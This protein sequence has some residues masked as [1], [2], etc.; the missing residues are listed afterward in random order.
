MV[1]D[2]SRPYRKTGWRLVGLA[3]IAAAIG[4]PLSPVI[5]AATPASADIAIPAACSAGWTN[6][7][8][9]KCVGSNL[10]VT[11]GGNNESSFSYYATA[12]STADPIS[13]SFNSTLVDHPAG[14][15]EGGDGMAI[16]LYDA[17]KGTPGAPGQRG[18]GLGVG[19]LPVAG[20]GLDTYQDPCDP[21]IGFV[22]LTDGSTWTTNTCGTNNLHYLGASPQETA[23]FQSGEPVTVTFNAASSTITVSLGGTQ[24]FTGSLTIPANAYLFISGG[25]GAATNIE[26]VSNFSGSIA[27]PN[28][29]ATLTASSPTITA[30]RSVSDAALVSALTSSAGGTQQALSLGHVSLGHVSLGHVSL[31]HVSLGHV[32]LGH[33]SLGHVS[34]GHVAAA[35]QALA[36][37]TVDT[38]PVQYPTG[39]SAPAVPC[40]G[41]TG[42]LAGSGLAGA[43]LQG[44]TLAQVLADPDASARFDALPMGSVDFS[45]TPLASVPMSVIALAGTPLSSI[46]LPGVTDDSTTGRLQGWCNALAAQGYSSCFGIDPSQPGTASNISPLTLALAG[47]QVDNLSL[48]SISLGHVSLGHVSLGHV[49]LGQVDLSASSLGHVSL[50][51][52]SLGHVA[53][54]SIPVDALADPGSVVNCSATD[55][56]GTSF[57]SSS[58]D[59][60]ADAEAA[61]AVLPGA[62]LDD[63]ANLNAVSLGHVALSS[64]SLGHVSLGHV[65]LGQVDVADSSLGHVSL[66]HVSLGHVPLGEIPLDSIPSLG[67]VVDCSA[68]DSGGTSFCTS[69]TDTLADA[70]SANAVLATA[71]LGQLSNLDAASLG[72]VSLGHVNMATS[73]LGHVSLGQVDMADSSLGQVS[74]GHV[75]LG[76]V[77]LGEIPLDSISD[78]GAVVDC[79]ATDSSGNNLCS[80]SSDTLADAEVAGAILPTATLDQLTDLDQT[81]L[82]HVSLGHV[83]LSQSASLGQVELGAIPDLSSVV[84][85]S[86]SDPNSSP[87]A[88]FCDL[89]NDELWQA[90]AAGAVLPNATLADLGP[91]LGTTLGQLGTY[92]NATLADLGPFL[93]TTLAELGAYGNATLA[94]LG[95]FLSTTVEQLL[96]ELDP[97]DPTFSNM[98]LDDLLAG[99]LPPSTYPWDTV[100][101]STLPLDQAASAPATDTFTETLTDT[102]VTD[103]LSSFII[104]LP[105]GFTYV[106]GSTTADGNAVPDAT[107][108]INGNTLSA[109]SAPFGA[110]TPGTHTVTVEGYPG[111]SIGVGRATATVTGT[112]SASASTDVTVV[113]PAADGNTPSNPLPLLT[114]N[115]NFGHIGDAGAL[116]YWAITVNQGDE[117]ALELSNLPAD[118]DLALFSPAGTTSSESGQLQGAPSTQAP[119]VTD[120]QP[121]LSTS[122]EPIPGAGDVAQAA[123]P[124]FQTYAISDNRGNADEN[125]QTPPLDAGTYLVEVSGYNGDS[126]DAPYLLRATDLATNPNLTCTPMVNPATLTAPGTSDPVPANVNTII[127]VNTQALTA[128]VGAGQEQ[129]AWTAL[130]NLNGAGGVVSARIAVDADPATRADYAAWAGGNPCSVGAANQVVH[131]IISQLDALRA[132]HPSITSVV[133]V[134]G[135]DEIPFARVADGAAQANE[136]DYAAG[137]FPGESNALAQSLAEGYYLSDDPLT[138]MQPLGVGSATLYTP[139]LAVGRLVTTPSTPGSSSG[140]T[141]TA[142]I[143]AANRFVQYQGVLTADSELTTGYSFLTAGAQVVSSDLTSLT[144]Q[145]V[146]DLINESWTHQQLDTALSAGPSIVGLNAHFDFGRALPAAGNAS[147]DETDLFTTAD[148]RG[149]AQS[150]AGRL[151]FSMGCHSGLN[152]DDAEV[153]TSGIAS[154]VDDWAKTFADEGA[155]WIGNTGYGYADTDTI[156]YSAKLMA[157]FAG[158]LGLSPTIGAALVN[159]KQAYGAGDALLSPYDLKGLMEA[160]FYG[161]PMYKVSAT[162]TG[163]GAPPAPATSVDPYTGLS[164]A[165]ITVTPTFSSPQSPTGDPG[166]SYYETTSITVTDTN[167]TTYTQ[168]TGGQTQETEYRPLEP[169][170]TVDVTEPSGAV[171]HGALVTGLAS[172]D[173][174]IA[175][176][177]AQPDSAGGGTG[178]TPIAADAPFPNQI[179]RV[180]SSESLTNTGPVTHQYL[181]LVLG[182]YL[183]GSAPGQGTQRLFKKVGASVFFTAPTDQDFTPAAIVSDSATSTGNAVDFRV[184]TQDA[185]PVDRVLVLYTDGDNPGAWTP[186]NLG[187]SDGSNWTGTAPAPTSGQV[188]FVVQVLD[189]NGNVAVASNKGVG[190]PLTQPQGSSGNLTLSA[191]SVGPSGYYDAPVPVT[192]SGGTGTGF[193]YTIDGGPSTAVPANDQIIVTGDGTHVVTA[194]DDGGD[195]ASIVIRINTTPPDLLSARV[196]GGSPDVLPT[197]CPSKDLVNCVTGEQWRT[198]LDLTVPGRGLSLDLTRTYSSLAA[199]VLGPFGYGWTDSYNVFLSFS[200]TSVT[201]HQ[202]NGSTLTATAGVNGYVF[203][204][205]VFATLVQNLN[206]TFTFTTKT[207]TK[208]QFSAIG[209]LLSL[210]DRNGYVTSFTY[211]AAGQLTTVTDPAGRSLHFSYRKNLVSSVTDPAG[212]VVSYLYD[213]AGDLVRSYDAGRRAW[214]YSYDAQ[215]RMVGMSDPRGDSTTTVYDGTGRVVSQTDPMGRTTTHSYSAAAGT[216]FGSTTVTDPRGFQTV[217]DYAGGEVTST[218]QGVNTPQQ[219]TTSYTYDPATLAQTSSTDPRGNTTTS[220]YDGEGNLLSTT[221]PMGRTTSYTYNALNEP[222]TVTDPSGITTTSVYD[223]RGNLVSRTTGGETTSYTYGDALHPGDVTAIT[224]PDGYITHF[225]YDADGNQISVT[226]ADGNTSSSTY[227]GIGRMISSTTPNQKTTKYTYD[228]MDDLLTVTD[229][230]GHKATNVYDPA[231][232]VTATVDRSGNTTEYVYDRDNELTLTLQRGRT[233]R[234]AYDAAGDVISSTDGAGRVTNYEYD[235]LDRRTEVIDPLGHTTATAYDADGNAVSVT[236]PSGRVTSNAYDAD[237]ELTSTTYSDGMTPPVSYTY[238]AD[239]RRTSMTDGTGTTTYGYDPVGR[240]ASST[241]GDGQAVGYGYDADGRVTTLT[242]PNGENVTQGYDPDGNMTSVTDWL[243]HTTTFTYDPDG[244]QTTDTVGSATPVTNTSTYDGNDQLLSTTDSQGATTLQQ[245]DY[246]RNADGLVSSATPQGEPTQSYAYDNLNRL[247]RDGQGAYIYDRGDNLTTFEGTTAMRY[248][249]GDELVSSQVG[250]AITSYTYDAEGERTK[251][252]PPTGPSTSYIYDQAGNLVGFDR[253]STSATYT[254][255][256]DGLRMSKVVGSET[257]NSAYDTTGTAPRMLTDGTDNYIYGPQGLPLEVLTGSSI[258]YFF[259]HDQGGNTIM[260]TGDNGAAVATYTY[261]SFGRV[262]SET[263]SVTT[264]FLYD[265]Q[266]Q[267]AESGLYLTPPGYYD[268]GTGQLLRASYAYDHRGNPYGYA[269]EDPLNLPRPGGSQGVDGALNGPDGQAPAAP[270]T[271]AAVGDLGIEPVPQPGQVSGDLSYSRNADVT[272][273]TVSNNKV[274]VATT[275]STGMTLPPNPLVGALLRLLDL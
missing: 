229:P 159:A 215:H 203:P 89:P 233:V 260:L 138:A 27:Q 113:D 32:S 62:T 56:G 76:H 182:Q 218:T 3:V 85:C 151:L 170:G 55:S 120:N 52:V 142:I 122:P 265:G 224:D 255:D 192:V 254:Y 171:A 177:V 155:L 39:C 46:L 190:F 74:L 10:E 252:S 185:S 97:N 133:V 167:N 65:S 53:M 131:D 130:G 244:N 37:I 41:W 226:D 86:V 73:S 94:D 174:S 243:G 249:A 58:T 121:G 250:R 12:L 17:S 268:P 201:L 28:L 126:S 206:G 246:T 71:T 158:E 114:D 270:V 92:G 251:T 154:G 136:R 50:G 163:A 22:G 140:D 124:G 166:T 168:P 57:C 275:A 26:T 4:A 48:D 34:L 213:A 51:H 78:V 118:Y 264:P 161:L 227:D 245:Y 178:S 139:Q 162:E 267:D 108:S 117:L 188:D 33:V 146:G 105:P 68:T 45:N 181:D 214:N 271:G 1:T 240:L 13:V 9:A 234:T 119:T 262:A 72:H 199:G 228:A 237:N 103:P 208:Y 205:Y 98:T 204:A 66:G 257:S 87:S 195:H 210:S 64:L 150:F 165:S 239:G 59:T 258:S 211:N 15:P 42:L 261:D 106:P 107:W 79:S 144:G 175:P 225:A 153:A 231:G 95:P 75:S 169:S 212:R 256:G 176:T 132:A 194:A 141:A 137:T 123:P 44:V 173:S 184:V 102:E 6:L 25:S 88:S 5:L 156:A 84:D 197:A 19:G 23:L 180:S 99:I 269:Q 216:G 127:L 235:A 247:V 272:A 189:A 43:P 111:L 38:M 248:N 69:S 82:G 63:L 152:I 274:L 20:V 14:G 200:G 104:T 110:L 134:G 115:L 196:G 7:G 259:H 232:N 61:G 35:D 54:G 236:D 148:V 16:G 8:S 193:T 47:V 100:D 135:D 24:V 30:L 186:L 191:P 101:L 238:D 143:N 129:Q 221:D 172:S 83:D 112:A 81:S 2:R 145:S 220:T 217:Y 125:I 241:N 116:N 36:G 40:T 187:S 29:T 219:I 93:A 91:F 157:G 160:T 90:A 263:G 202:G 266:Y 164:D 18:G 253:G 222:L 21:T 223:G 230:L 31:G 179:Q 128:D 70:A 242:Y 80:S 207:G 11:D 109:T 96:V 149:A 60:L 77:P 273:V 209:R 147:G 67:S 49:S 198:F 183:P